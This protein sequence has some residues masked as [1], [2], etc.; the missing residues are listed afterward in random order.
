MRSMAAG[1]IEAVQ[2]RHVYRL[3]SRNLAAG[4]YSAERAG[5]IGI[6]T[7]FGDRYLFTEYWKETAWPLE[8]IGVLPESIEIRERLASVDEVSGREVEYR[9]NDLSLEDL[10]RGWHYK[11]TG[12][13][14]PDI[15]PVSRQYQPLF[16]YLE[17][18]ELALE[19]K[20]PKDRWSASPEV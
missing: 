1:R 8:E 17:Q 12:E 10:R 2:D 13:K 11:D 5:F 4:V 20:M 6:R 18:V 9:G 15:R 3:R 14:N 19:S 7:K 16:D